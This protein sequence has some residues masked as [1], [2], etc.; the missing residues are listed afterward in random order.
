MRGK[1][2]SL[3]GV[4]EPEVSF[5]AAYRIGSITSKEYIEFIDRQADLAA[6]LFLLHRVIT[7]TIALPIP[8]RQ[9]SGFQ[10]SVIRASHS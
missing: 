7:V 6:D 3:I 10:M 4:L 8:V 1:R 5:D 9:Y 2:V